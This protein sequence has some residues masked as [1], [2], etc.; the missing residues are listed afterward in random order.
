MAA[1]YNLQKFVYISLSSSLNY[2]VLNSV[3]HVMSRRE[4]NLITNDQC[5]KTYFLLSLRLTV[6]LS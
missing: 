1:A 6:S 2:V 3:I 4:L 5:L